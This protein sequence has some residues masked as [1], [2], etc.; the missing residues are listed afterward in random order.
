MA[1]NLFLTLE[2]RAG[3]P[4][5]PS[6]SAPTGQGAI[7]LKGQQGEGTR[8]TDDSRKKRKQLTAVRG[9]AHSCPSAV[10]F[11][12]SHRLSPAIFIICIYDYYSFT[13]K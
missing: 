8:T 2:A 3:W 13:P 11:L 4:L 6:G 5:A 9:A 12:S 10:S 7:K 1:L